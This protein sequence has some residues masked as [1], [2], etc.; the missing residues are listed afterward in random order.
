MDPDGNLMAYHKKYNKKNLFYKCRM[1]EKTG[2][3]VTFTVD[4]TTEIITRHN[5]A[6]HSHDSEVA[7]HRVKE[8]MEAAVNK[9]TTNV[10]KN[11]TIVRSN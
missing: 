1:K 7:E 8:I 11:R 10:D 3:P 9:T 4:S 5:D 2:C 6:E